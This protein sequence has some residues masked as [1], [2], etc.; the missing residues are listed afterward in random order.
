MILNFKTVEDLI[1]YD[2]IIQNKLPEF[3][4]LFKQ[5]TMGKVHPEV[6]FLSKKAVL[7]FLKKINEEHIKILSDYF[8]CEIIVQKVDINIVKTYPVI[9]LENAE[10]F[11]N[12]LE[13][14]EINNL[15]CYRDANQIYLSTWR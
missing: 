12:S 6:G 1:F 8:N 15:V 14:D 10:S 3:S 4:N 5:W 13:K 11:L 7:D 9:G 2:K